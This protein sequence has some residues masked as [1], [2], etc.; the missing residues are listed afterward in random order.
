[1]IYITVILLLL[2]TITLIWISTSTADRIYTDITE[3]PHNRVGLIPGCNKYITQG[4]LNT[5]YTQ[6]IDAAVMLYT[7]GKIDFILV[8]GDNGHPSY[9]EPREM[10]NS[11]IEAGIPKEKIYADYAG[12]RTLDTI[13]RA[14]E[15]FQ[16]NSVTFIS[17]SFQNRRGIFI[18]SFNDMDVIAFNAD[19]MVHRFNIKIALREGFAK[20]KMLLDLYIIGEEPKFLG[21][22][23]H[24]N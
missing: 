2:I 3:L 16:L 20:I 9:D 6:R 11:L 18:G 23:I 12:F 21:D 1:M 10:K 8:S 13:V 17:Q 15:V 19:Y 22:P 5:Y 14:K 4:V 24:I 7:E